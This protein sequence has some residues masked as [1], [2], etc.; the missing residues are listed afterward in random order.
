MF[1]A[2]VVDY[3]GFCVFQFE[4]KKECIKYADREYDFPFV[5]THYQTAENIAYKLNLRE[6]EKRNNYKRVS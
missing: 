1:Y 3:N 2:I 5:T 4:D 6:I